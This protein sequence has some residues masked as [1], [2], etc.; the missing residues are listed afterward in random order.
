LQ[1]GK[2]SNFFLIWFVASTLQNVFYML[3]AATSGGIVPSNSLEDTAASEV[4]IGNTAE[5]IQNS[6]NITFALGGWR[7]S[8]AVN[9]FVGEFEARRPGFLEHWQAQNLPADIARGYSTML[10][11]S[12]VFFLGRPLDE[13]WA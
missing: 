8:K 12:L 4:Y 1:D 13:L 6:Y 3:E 9:Y 5:E 11:G 2:Y 7:D 10:V